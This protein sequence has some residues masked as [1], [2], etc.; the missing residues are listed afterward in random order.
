MCPGREVFEEA[1][2]VA[3]SLKVMGFREGDQIPVFLR[4]V[5]EF[6]SLLLAAEKIGASV[7]CRDN[8]L[9]ENVEAAVKAGAKII[10]VHDFLSQEEKAA[11][12]AGGIET[13]ITLSPLERGSPGEYAPA[14]PELSGFLLS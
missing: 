7:L 5:P 11:F 1:E 3:R 4:L 12:Q 13:I 2:Q 9:E 6:I 8:T 10:F 14:C